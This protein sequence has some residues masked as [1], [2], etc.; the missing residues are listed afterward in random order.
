MELQCGYMYYI[1]NQTIK[2]IQLNTEFQKI[3][4]KK[5]EI[6]LRKIHVPNDQ[7]F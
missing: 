2:K 3:K 7:C 5:S 4:E 1:E 6:T